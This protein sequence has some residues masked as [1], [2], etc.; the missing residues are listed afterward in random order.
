MKSICRIFNIPNGVIQIFCC[1][2]HHTDW[3]FLDYDVP[4]MVCIIEFIMGDKKNETVSSFCLF[5]SV[6]SM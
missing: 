1:F 4:G 2:C 5:Y 6:L 3:Y